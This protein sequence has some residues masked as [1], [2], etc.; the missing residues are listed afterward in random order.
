M[1]KTAV[2]KLISIIL[3]IMFIISI[4]YFRV[5][6][7]KI[8]TPFLLATAITYVLKPIVIKLENRKMSTSVSII[9]VYV[10]FILFIASIVMFIIPELMSSIRE[11]INSVPDI[12]DKYQNMFA[13]LLLN[14]QKINWSDEIKSVLLY[15][16]ENGIEMVQD[17][18][19]RILGKTLD[20][21]MK[22][23]SFIID[24]VLA[25]LI[26]YYFIRDR[27]L[28]KVL[29]L[30]AVPKRWQNILTST[31]RDINTVLSNFM[32]GQLLT[33]LIIGTLESIGLS[34]VG[35]KY[36]LVLGLIGGISN[37]IPY[38]GPFIGAIPSTALALLDSPSKA[39]WTIFVFVIIQQLDNI[40]ISAKIIEDRLG[41]HPVTT[42]IIVII[43]EEFFGI[44]GM[45][46]AV[47]VYAI[48]KIIFKRVVNA[49][50]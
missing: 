25:L 17:Y 15:E 5:K 42:I 11:L 43:G 44:M 39:L 8:I 41:L 22:T 48:L 19:L 40:F 23:V 27:G 35:V 1:K 49:L 26:A 33:A 36:P 47:P 30:S 12:T 16:I 2:I 29:F 4:I 37:I 18:L 24:F 14:I 34:I 10:L 21:I 32:Q 45:I 3:L 28:F 31:G 6:I 20:T 13:G 50:A 7:I 38:F 9:L 46:L